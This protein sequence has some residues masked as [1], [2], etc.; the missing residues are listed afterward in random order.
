[1]SRCIVMDCTWL[2][3]N[4]SRRSRWSPPHM[5]HGAPNVITG[6]SD[7]AGASP[8]ISSIRFT[9]RA[10]LPPRECPVNRSRADL[11]QLFKWAFT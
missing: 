1:M 9:S 3:G 6:S 5:M 11:P 2:R 8:R 4:P 7:D 10:R